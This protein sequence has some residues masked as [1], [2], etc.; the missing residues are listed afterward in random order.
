M[1]RSLFF[2]FFHLG[3]VGAF[4]RDSLGTASQLEQ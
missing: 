4:V 1:E 3:A 2:F